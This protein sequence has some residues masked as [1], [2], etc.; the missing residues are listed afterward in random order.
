MNKAEATTSGDGATAGGLE[1]RIALVGKNLCRSFA[2]LIDTLP[3]RPRQPVEVCRTL[4]INRDLSGR[5]VKATRNRD[6]LSSM[7]IMP[8]PE[9]LRLVLRAVRRKVPA[10]L[11]RAAEDAVVEFETLVR[12]VA[13]D[14]TALDAIVSAWVP[15]ARA[16]FEAISKHTAFKGAAYVKG[17]SADV[18]V[19]AIFVA[20]GSSD[21]RCAYMSVRG[22]VGL[23]RLRPGS[24]VGITNGYNTSGSSASAYQ[25]TLEGHPIN[26]NPREALLSE[27]CSPP[28]PAIAIHDC[29]T[30]IHYVLTDNQVGL[31][32]SVNLFFADVIDTVGRY[33]RPDRR[34]VSQ[35]AS[36][37][38]PTRLLI[39]DV[40][41][42]GSIWPDTHPELL[43]LDSAIRGA[44]NPNDPGHGVA[45]INLAETIQF[46]GEGVSICR[47]EAV[48]DYVPLLRHACQRMSWDPEAFR[49]HRCQMQY[50][51]YGS[52]V[53][54][55]FDPPPRQ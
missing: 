19:C 33:S 45:R 48:P 43:I 53:H 32:S 10:G 7:G 35:A 24:G 51:F 28:S 52:I 6:P 18:N 37:D 26:Q 5:I 23:R 12:D 17:C 29:G 36:I 4:R 34:K 15:E 55:V 2:S 1:E 21:D 14:R 11:I 13:G 22:L 50:P 47:A 25:T 38:V 3:G 31:E 49:V 39:F 8:G 20:P 44:V 42:H 54:A 30:F 46:L 40:L 9:G 41:V 16:K 27:F